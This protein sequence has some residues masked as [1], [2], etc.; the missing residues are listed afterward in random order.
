[1]LRYQIPQAVGAIDGTHIN[2]VAPEGEGKVFSRK[3]RYTIETQ[4]VVGANLIFHD[5]ATGF[6]GSCHD[7]SNLRNSSI[8]RCAENDEIL[9]KPVEIVHDFEVRPFIIGD[10]AYLGMSS[11]T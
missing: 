4:G 3:Q 5:M 2:I 6:P 11:L 10:S 9:V 8:F 7:A 1:M